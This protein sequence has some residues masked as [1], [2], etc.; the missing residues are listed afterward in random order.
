M[1]K[2]NLI[3]ESLAKMVDE[4]LQEMHMNAKL[5]SKSIQEDPFMGDIGKEMEGN[6]LVRDIMTTLG[7]DHKLHQE[8]MAA[9]EGTSN[10]AE[11][12]SYREAIRLIVN[13]IDEKTKMVQVL[14]KSK[15]GMPE[16]VTIL[17]KM[18][19]EAVE[20]VMT[21]KA[22]PGLEDMVLGLKKKYGEDSPRPFQIAWAHY[23]KTKGK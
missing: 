18:V 21:E 10:P 23:N 2:K 3:G 14:S 7:E 5:K 17:T 15:K 19:H 6:Y 4:A 9:M 1:A 22:P 8:I 20:Q 16:G 11:L 13:T 12:D